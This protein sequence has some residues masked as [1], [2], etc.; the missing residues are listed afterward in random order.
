MNPQQAAQQII[1]L[2][3]SQ[4]HEL[5]SGLF[6]ENLVKSDI[7]GRPEK[8]SFY[9]QSFTQSVESMD[10]I[11][12]L[13]GDNPTAEELISRAKRVKAQAQKMLDYVRNR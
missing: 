3:S 1:Q 10:T 4:E 6:N 7:A 13:I 8:R 5:F 2:I 9:I 11:L 12:G